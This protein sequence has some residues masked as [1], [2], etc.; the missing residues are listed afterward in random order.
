MFSLGIGQCVNK[1]EDQDQSS[2]MN[3]P[4]ESGTAGLVTG[5]S[6]PFLKFLTEIFYQE[7]EYNTICGYR[8]AISAYHDSVCPFPVG[9]HSY[10]RCFFNNRML[11]SR[12]CFT[13]DVEKVLSF[14]N[15]LDS[16][17]TELKI[18]TYKVTMLLALT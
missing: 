2:I 18:L 4:G 6:I 15:S 11:Q 7:L 10:I 12:Y 3:R 17:R 13:L 1:Q 5:V 14:L 8:S 16:E 9:N